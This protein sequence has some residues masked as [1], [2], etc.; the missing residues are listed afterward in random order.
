MTAT[1]TP[2]TDTAL[3]WECPAVLSVPWQAACWVAV[4]GWRYRAPLSPVYGSLLLQVAAAQNIP[5]WVLVIGTIAATALAYLVGRIREFPPAW[6][7]FSVG[8]AAASGSWLVAA[9]ASGQMSPWVAA[10][11]AAGTGG[12]TWW[13]HHLATRHQALPAPRPVLE[14]L[15]T[16]PHP[17]QERIDDTA[18]R[19]MALRHK[20]G[21]A[22]LE[23][24]TEDI[25]T[26]GRFTLTV[27][28]RRHT[29]ALDADRDTIAAVLGLPVGMLRRIT[30][31]AEDAGVQVWHFQV[32][33]P[34]GGRS[35]P[36]VP[37]LL[38]G[39]I[40][41]PISIGVAEDEEEATMLLAH[42]EIGVYHGATSGKTGY[43]KTVHQQVV[44]AGTANCDDAVVLVGDLKPTLDFAPLAPVVPW[45][46]TTP[47]EVTMMLVAL[48]AL[49]EPG[50]GSRGPLKRRA[51]RVLIPD[52][53]AVAVL[54]LLDEMRM[55]F[56]R[57]MNPQHYKEANAA[58]VTIALLGRAL[59][60]AI[61]VAGQNMSEPA[62]PQTGE[63]S[64]TEFR[65]QLHHRRIFHEDSASSGQF[66]LDD[67]ARLDVTTLKRPGRLYHAAGDA[68][69]MPILGYDIPDREK[70]HTWAL[71]RARTMPGVDER[72]ARLLGEPFAT[73]HRRIPAELAEWL[74]SAAAT[75]RPP[76][77]PTPRPAP[78]EAA[79]PAREAVP[80]QRPA[81]EN[82]QVTA[83][84]PELE[85]LADT[86]ESAGDAGVG[87]A[88][89]EERVGK[90][91]SWVGARLTALAVD[92]VI[93]RS[94]AGPGVR[95]R[96]M[97]G[98]DRTRLR[99]AIASVDAAF[100][101]IHTTTSSDGK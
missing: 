46:G 3:T 1:D 76:A 95:W 69:S 90:R 28:S 45:Y 50:P 10:A 64:G 71:R 89:L 88:V 59:G 34:Y 82:P 81:E 78:E 40:L 39:T 6:T 67:Y 53:D 49:C 12:A 85:A 48:A 20:I 19:L 52:T 58:A 21:V 75:V 11:W 42:P 26:D 22:E 7:A 57:E 38:A 36:W 86:L 55:V 96:V 18:R 101:L 99:E 100:R 29:R 4:N 23:I 30:P 9:E 65:A 25:V 63:R 68:P 56:S 13:R 62:M 16:P 5:G 83:L 8:C 24:L 32:G 87:R 31:V 43:G 44:G 33:E 51:D 27:R 61:H 84:S 47:E 70:L 2:G 35:I 93:H 14:L 72:T 92:G 98:V 41:E 66:L 94:G 73:R 80:N 17:L 60:V 91:R 97:P 79:T 77:A 37:P 74:P 54:L 15:P